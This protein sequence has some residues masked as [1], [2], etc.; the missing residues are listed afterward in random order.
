MKSLKLR[1]LKNWF[2]DVVEVLPVALPASIAV[3]GVVAVLFLLLGKFETM[4]I[5]MVG[6]PLASLTAFYLY[7]K[8]QQSGSYKKGSVAER[9]FVGVI[10]LVL[11][12]SWIGFNSL[13]NAQH[14]YTNRDPAIYAVAG[15][16]LVDHTNLDIPRLPEFTSIDGIK[17][18]S[19]GFGVSTQD[20]NEIYAQ[21]THILPAFLGLFGRAVG[22]LKIY[23]LNA[24]LGGVALLA[25]YGFARLIV[26]PRWALAAMM[27]LGASLPHLY[28]S[29]D[30][31][32]EPLALAFT[33]G[34]LA[35]IVSAY[36]S[37]KMG[38]WFVAGLTLGAG[39][40]TRIDAYMAL[41]FTIPFLVAYLASLPQK[42][43]VDG[44]RNVLLL[45]IGVF[46]TA[47]IGYLDV[48]YLSSGYFRD[49]WSL[50]RQEL[51]LIMG[52]SVAGALV[53][54]V[55]WYT[56][57]LKYIDK[58][59]RNWRALVCVVIL[60]LGFLGLA[61]RP[62]V[63]DEYQKRTVVQV[64]GTKQV[65]QVKSYKEDAVYWVAWYIGP[66]AMALGA[67]GLL[68]MVYRM[69]GSDDDD[70]LLYLLITS[71]LICTSLIYFLKP[72]I[73]SDQ[74]WASRRMLPVIMPGFLVVG[75]FLL[76]EIYEGR[77][78]IIKKTRIKQQVL[79]SVLVTAAVLTPL[80]I[81][82]P[83]IDKA[84]FTQLSG[85][86][87]TCKALP[88][89]SSVL[90]VG[91]AKHEAPITTRTFCG[92]TSL[93][94]YPKIGKPDDLADKMALARFATVSASQGKVPVLGRFDDDPLID[95]ASEANSAIVAD[96][97]FTNVEYVK[98]R[99]PRTSTESKRFI[100]LSIISAD[101][102]L[103]P[104][105]FK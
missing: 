15:A 56:N 71:I 64:D 87:G 19:A 37:G 13:F 63:F 102:S 52:L 74:I 38:L 20:N 73:A 84:P 4:P 67:I 66:L 50:V 104:L 42:S 11:V 58:L 49:T 61:I 89:D 94:Y 1:S 22:Q 91:L 46:A 14:V 103:K 8:E 26:K 29:R 76:Q 80:L 12:L 101:G 60:S 34:A 9:R 79:A 25:L 54:L 82:I 10:A 97:S 30:T 100:R 27:A 2:Y 59:T 55:S 99:V 93:G 51:L 5:L 33:F 40:L 53:V 65:E 72:S 45:A 62:I 23:P 70:S 39:V 6:L 78:L 57:F 18:T 43:R 77:F 41:A 17:D 85:V 44:L 47:A 36:K 92:E 7:K 105:P 88:A 31:Y 68:V 86:I 16:W 35:L 83:F 95:T 48:K 96:G 98:G 90:W 28:F 75:M 69:L 3:F 21:G 81:S 24:V 32:T